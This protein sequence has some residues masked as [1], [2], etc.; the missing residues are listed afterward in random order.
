MGANCRAVLFRGA[1]L[2]SNRLLTVLE[3]C[4]VG[5]VGWDVWGRG[6]VVLPALRFAWVEGT[7]T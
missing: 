1:V 4:E 7:F 5:D 2:D 3:E 6:V